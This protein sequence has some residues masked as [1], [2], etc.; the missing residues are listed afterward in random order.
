VDFKAFTKT[1]IVI[2]AAILVLIQNKAYAIK[3]IPLDIHYKISTSSMD[4]VPL[5]IMGT[6]FLVVLAVYYKVS[7]VGKYETFSLHCNIC[8]SLTRGLKCVV[9]EGRKK[10]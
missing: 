4:I 8:G 3:G 5:L 7:K 10:I 6:I 1:K 9:C 2:F